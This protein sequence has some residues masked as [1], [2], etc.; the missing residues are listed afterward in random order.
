[1]VEKGLRCDAC[2]S[3]L[4]HKFCPNCNE[5]RTNTFLVLY[6]LFPCDGNHK[7]S[8]KIIYV[9]GDDRISIV[10]DDDDTSFGHDNM[11]QASDSA[12]EDDTRRPR[13]IYFNFPFTMKDIRLT[14]RHDCGSPL[15]VSTMAIQSYIEYHGMPCYAGAAVTTKRLSC[16]MHTLPSNPNCA[17]FG[18]ILIE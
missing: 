8:G 13:R 12:P 9:V 11:L 3:D 14:T 16:K 1:M 15:M 17:Q 18:G 6:P 4:V 10:Y 7:L 5:Y 2:G